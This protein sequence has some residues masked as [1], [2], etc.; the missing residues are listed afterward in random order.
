M[1]LAH[2]CDMCHRIIKDCNYYIV[3]TGQ[4]GVRAAT[5]TEYECCP[6][7]HRKVL[8]VLTEGRTQ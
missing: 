4:A 7:C 1:S 8:A 5:R 2:I 3:S 6:D